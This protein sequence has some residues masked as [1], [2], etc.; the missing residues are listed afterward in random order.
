MTLRPSSPVPI[1]HKRMATDALSPSLPPHVPSSPRDFV[2]N[3]NRLDAALGASPPSTAGPASAAGP[4]VA[5]MGISDSLLE[6]RSNTKDTALSRDASLDP[7][8]LSDLSTKLN[9]GP[10]STYVFTRSRGSAEPPKRITPTFVSSSFQPGT[11]TTST[12]PQRLLPPGATG[13]SNLGNTCF[14]NSALQCLSHTAPLTAFFLSNLWE[15]QLNL[16]NPLGMN[17]RMAK[18]YAHLIE[19]LWN[20][21]RSRSSFSPREFKYTM[22]EFNSL[23]A[24]Y[25][26]Q[27][28]QELLQ[29][30]LDGLH[31]DLNRILK[32]PYVQ[33]PDMDHLPDHEIAE[34][35]WEFYSLRNDSVIVD[36]FQGQYKSRVECVHCGKWSI[37]FDPY[38]FLSLP[39]PGTREILIHV[40]V[41]SQSQHEILDARLQ[42]PVRLA[43]VLPKDATIQTLVE[44]LGQRLGWNRALPAA[45][46]VVE[47]FDSKIYKIFDP[48]DTLA[49]IGHTDILYVLGPDFAEP[50]FKFVDWQPDNSFSPMALPTLSSLA[51]ATFT[52][53]CVRIPVY[54]THAAPSSTFKPGF[55]GSLFGFPF[56]LTFPS[57]IQVRIPAHIASRLTEEQKAEEV[58][59]LFGLQLFKLLIVN[60]IRFFQSIVTDVPTDPKL[61][62]FLAFFASKDVSWDAFADFIK[63][64]M[65]RKEQTGDSDTF[66][67]TD[68]ANTYAC[69]HVLVFPIDPVVPADEPLV[70]SVDSLGDSSTLGS[71]TSENIPERGAIEDHVVVIDMPVPSLFIMQ[72]TTSHAQ[73]VF[74]VNGLAP[75]KDSR[76]GDPVFTVRFHKF[77]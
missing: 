57:Q 20:P 32:K 47:I 28:S 61:S 55:H 75:I 31:E 64:I 45:P 63:L 15:Q 5:G 66:Y 26:Q 27:D 44:S 52:D 42:V 19:N 14:M 74:S 4:T 23:F 37:K 49:Q 77:G 71:G 3:S 70:E 67:F 29:S 35:S 46:W 16:D 40:I 34:K 73:D 39:I 17:G 18:A 33:V 43:V 7:E 21:A 6:T 24:G 10:L 50:N 62:D 56:F 48:K 51:L 60:T 36:L 59:R 69:S 2:V 11:L 72:W 13:L 22:G 9:T 38:M 68:W 12:A 8:L 41:L 1:S 25:G 53:P 76:I 54:L 65:V 30:L 58:K